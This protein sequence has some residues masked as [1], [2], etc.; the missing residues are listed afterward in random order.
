LYEYKLQHPCPCSES[1]P[2]CLTFHHKDPKEKEF[3]IGACI[4]K[5][6]S[7]EKILIEIAKCEV[8]CMNC[9]AKYHA[10]EKSL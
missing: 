10:K 7:W 9:H 8:L 1:D 3:E 4:S 2:V 5:G 6:L